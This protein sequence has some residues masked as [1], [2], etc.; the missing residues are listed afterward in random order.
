MTDQPP[1]HPREMPAELAALLGQVVPAGG[2]FGHRE[3]V[4][5]T[6]LTVRRDGTA[7]AA[8][9]IASWIRHIANTSARRRSTTRR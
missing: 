8:T 4:H 9:K 6:F 7:A 2:R 1:A 3:H 5:L